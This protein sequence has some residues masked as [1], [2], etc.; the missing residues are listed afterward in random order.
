MWE[1]YHV[2]MKFVE[3][4]GEADSICR[5]VAEEG[6]QHVH[7][8]SAFTPLLFSQLLNFLWKRALNLLQ[9]LTPIKNLLLNRCKV[10]NTSCISQLARRLHQKLTAERLR[11]KVTHHRITLCVPIYMQPLSPAV[12]YSY[13]AWRV[14]C[15]SCPCCRSD[16]TTF[17][18]INQQASQSWRI[19]AR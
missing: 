17:E 19:A 10:S 11:I 6:I 3:V 7:L 15:Y 13:S 12:H 9:S 16:A 2:L 14:V 4:G 8:V 18:K 1:Y 5:G